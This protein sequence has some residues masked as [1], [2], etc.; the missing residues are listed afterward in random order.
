M[1][2]CP[3]LGHGLHHPLLPL[4]QHLLL[5]LLVRGRLKGERS[6]GH[7]SPLVNKSSGVK[8]AILTF[9][10]SKFNGRTVSSG[11]HSISIP[12]WADPSVSL[13]TFASD[14]SR[15]APSKFSPPSAFIAAQI[16]V[17]HSREGLRNMDT[18]V[19]QGLLKS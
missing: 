4:P 1:E 15:R 6:K 8:L 7:E 9:L 12:A 10:K 14:I 18:F 13:I 5:L 2:D 16:T 3:P 19:I 17:R 11:L